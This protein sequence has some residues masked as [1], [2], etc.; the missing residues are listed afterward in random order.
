MPCSKSSNIISTSFG[1]SVSYDFDL[2]EFDQ[3]SKNAQDF[4]SQLL[5]LSPRVRLTA[6]QCLDHPWLM[7]KDILSVA[8]N[9]LVFEKVGLKMI[10][11]YIKNIIC[12]SKIGN[13]PKRIV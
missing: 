2:E 8:V 9:M 3:I 1:S 12:T 11:T 7:E 13:K 4:I 6:E 10:W 5:K